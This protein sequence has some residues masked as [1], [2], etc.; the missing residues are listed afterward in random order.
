MASIG[1][2]VQQRSGRHSLSIYLGDSAVSNPLLWDLG[3]IAFNFGKDAVAIGM[4]FFCSFKD[5]CVINVLASVD[6]IKMSST[7]FV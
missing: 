3:E 5:G 2:L 1:K 6:Q 7:F 4:S